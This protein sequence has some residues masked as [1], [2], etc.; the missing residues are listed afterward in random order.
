MASNPFS[1]FFIERLASGEKGMGAS[2]P[3]QPERHLA[4]A[5]RGAS[6]H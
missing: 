6:Q 5:R 2:I 1:H 4:L 3:S